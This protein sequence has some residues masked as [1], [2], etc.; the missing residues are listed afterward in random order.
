MFVWRGDCGVDSC[1]GIGLAG[2]QIAVGV[3][4][5]ATWQGWGGRGIPWV[6]TTSQGVTS[7]VGGCL[8]GTQSSRPLQNACPEPSRWRLPFRA[9]QG[10]QET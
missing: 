10:A 6:G 2:F 1:L 4:G 3:H 9:F 5:L 7:E 8:L